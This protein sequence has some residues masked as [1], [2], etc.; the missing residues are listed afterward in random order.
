MEYDWAHLTHALL[1]FCFSHHLILAKSL[2]RGK[3]DLGVRSKVLVV[4][5]KRKKRGRRHKLEMGSN[6][7]LKR[8]S[9]MDS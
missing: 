1:D 3:S 9:S 6:S 7:L 4:E 8:G 2:R 5:V